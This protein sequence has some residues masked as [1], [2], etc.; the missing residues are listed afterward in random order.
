MKYDRR[1]APILAATALLATGACAF[2]QTIAQTSTAPT[3]TA[4]AGSSLG[5][6]IVSASRTETRL[7]D[8]PLST[9]VL[10]RETLERSP[11]QT[12]DQVLATVPGINIS[13]QPGW[14]KDPTGQ[15]ISM[16]GLGNARTLVLVDGVPINDAF[17]GTVQWHLVPLSSI[18][19]VEIIRGGV[20]SLW[21]NYGMGGVINVVTKTPTGDGGE[22]SASLGSLH[23]AEIAMA[24][25]IA[26]S[27][28]LKL[29]VSADSFRTQGYQT[30]ATTHPAPANNV[31]AGQGTAYDRSSNVR[32]QAYWTPSAD[33]NGYFRLGYHVMKD[34][35]SNY[36]FALNTMQS[37]DLATG[38]TRRFDGGR[39]VQANFY[40]QDTSFNKANGSNGTPP[41]ASAT[42]VDPYKSMGGSVL[43][44]GAA[45]DSPRITAGVDFRR[46][47]GANTTRNLS[48]AG[49]LQSVV[50]GSGTQN[51]YGLLGQA[52]FVGR[53]VPLEATVGARYDYWQVARP[54]ATNTSASGAVTS[55][56]IAEQGKG[57]LN[58]S[59]ALRLAASDT[60]DLRAATYRAFHAPGMNNMFR[61]FGSSS[62]WSFSNP[63][64][65]PE[66]MLG[67]E[68][69]A[70]LRW[71]GGAL[72]A[73][74][75]DNRIRD[76]VVSANLSKSVAA[77]VALAQALCGAA[78]NPLAGTGDTGVCNSTSVGY[79]SNNQNL[80]SQGLELEMRHAFTPALSVSAGYALTYSRL[81][82]SQSSDPVGSQVGGVPKNTA[83]L[84]VQ[85]KP[86]DASTLSAQLRGAG[87]SWLDTKNTVPV[88]GYVTADLR[89]HH[90]VNRQVSVYGSLTNLFNLAY[91]TFGTGSSATSYTAGM[92]RALVGGV[93]YAF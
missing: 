48:P 20:S 63:N 16:R 38:V 13:G 52:V 89:A 31:K 1:I 64:L 34:L 6:V 84:G 78:G 61:S 15:S 14:S 71:R 8:M 73:T 11:A 10:T 56:P 92:P 46:I 91:V 9:T 4:T 27:D 17:Y 67:Y 90:Q 60:L 59:V 42:Y 36:A 50:V 3:S 45:K 43:W 39:Q 32:L 79:Y 66:Q 12:L 19:R 80:R 55:T 57:N 22:V 53:S 25:D 21:G 88:P 28:A 30:I 37:G 70:D 40:Y 85:W 75:F 54:E 93:R 49:A 41:Y 7:E 69:G 76:A 26:V 24:R 87:H 62:S 18:E 81:T 35:S 2:A 29:R 74:A 33:L 51:F 58:P 77:E 72:R 86:A 83:S 65:K 44:L 82:S 68:V 5:S 23:T 47:T